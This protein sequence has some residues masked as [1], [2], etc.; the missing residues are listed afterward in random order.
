VTLRIGAV[1][2]GAAQTTATSGYE[3][4]CCDLLQQVV[5]PARSS[6]TGGILRF[7]CVFEKLDLEIR[8]LGQLAEAALESVDPISNPFC[9]PFALIQGAGSGWQ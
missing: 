3:T 4:V 7:E 9:F 2:S 5:N 1:G 8:V 6:V